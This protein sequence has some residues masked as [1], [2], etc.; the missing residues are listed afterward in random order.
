VSPAN[1]A[2]IRFHLEGNDLH[3]RAE[4]D[5]GHV[6]EA[7]LDAA[8]VTAA[9]MTTARGWSKELGGLLRVTR[10]ALADRL[11]RQS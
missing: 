7:Q 1:R 10:K 8:E 4:D 6:I 9:M 5:Q 2:R 11:T 3:I